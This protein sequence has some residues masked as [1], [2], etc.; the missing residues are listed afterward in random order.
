METTPQVSAG[1]AQAAWVVCG[2]SR[3]G[4]LAI[5]LKREASLEPLENRAP[6]GL[7]I[8]DNARELMSVLRLSV[9]QLQSVG[10]SAPWA[11]FVVTELRAGGS[12]LS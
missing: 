12:Q 4:A 7:I 10:I 8:C 6:F 3:R 11:G 5:S 9:R 2:T 1:F